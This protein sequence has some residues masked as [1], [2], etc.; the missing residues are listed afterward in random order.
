MWEYLDIH[1]KKSMCII[2]LHGSPCSPSP[3]S[4]DTATPKLRAPLPPVSLETRH[5]KST[6]YATLVFKRR[7]SFA[8][9]YQNFRQTF[10]KN[11]LYK[12]HLQKSMYVPVISYYFR[13]TFA[14]KKITLANSTFN[15]SQRSFW[16]TKGHRI[17]HST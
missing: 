7:P 3:A 6:V 12:L 11:R 17:L 15:F 8:K 1:T 13:E 9:L 2:A 4:S 10:A 5:N 16:H 14:P